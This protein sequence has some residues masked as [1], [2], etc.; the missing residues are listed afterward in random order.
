MG[1]GVVWCALEV[2]YECIAKDAIGGQLERK[3]LEVWESSDDAQDLV[4]KS[5]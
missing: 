2:G 3:E 1:I 5:G 4:R